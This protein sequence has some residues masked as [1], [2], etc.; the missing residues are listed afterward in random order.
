[1]KA[2]ALTDN[3]NLYAAIDFFQQ[4]KKAEI[5][6]IIGIDAYVA[7]RTRKD[8]ESRIDN[9]RTRLIL[10][11]KDMTGYR[12]LIQLV[13]DAHLEGFYYKPR[14]D[15][16][17]IQ[18]WSDGLVC[19]SPDFNS[20]ISN[21][22]DVGDKERALDLVVF[23]KKTYGEENFFLEISR[24]PEIENH[25]QLEEKIIAFAKESNTQL[26]ASQNVFY[27]KKE[28]REARRT[29]MSVQQ[30]FGNAN[31]YDENEDF[32]FITQKQANE[33]F[34]NLPEALANTQKIADMCNI[35]IPIAVWKFPNYVIDSGL[36]PDE[37]F[38]RIVEEGIEVRKIEKTEEILTRMEYELD[39]IKEKGYSKYFL[40][41][42]DLLRYAR[43]N[44]IL[45]TIRGSVAGSLVTYLAGI[46]NVN[47]I[48]YKLPFE[49]FLNRE[50]PSAPD[51][52]MDYAE[53]RRDE[54]IEYARKKYGSAHVAQIGTFGTMLARGS[55]RDTTRA[56]GYD[57]QI[58][59]E[60][61]K[62]IPMGSQ[63][64]PMTIKRA[65]TEVSELAEKYKKNADFKK[66]IDMAKKIEGCARHIG[67]HAA[68]I[69]ISPDPL[70]VDVPLQFDPK[71][72]DKLITQ[73]NMHSVGE[74]G[75]GLLK[76]DF[77]G[78][79][80]LAILST[81]VKLV[82]KIHNI[83]IDIEAIPMDDKKTFEMLARGETIGVFQ[84]N[85]S[86]M[87]KSLKELKPS[88]IYDINAM[89]ALYRPGPMESIPKYIERKHN[90]DL[91]QY[92]DPRMEEI[93]DRSFG[94]ITYQDDVMMIAIKLA[95]YS[96]LEADKL[97]KAMGKKIPE[98]MQAEK[99]KLF[100]GLVTNGM[101]E[102]K[103]EEL[104]LLIEP[105]AAY[106][107]N[108][109]HAA[110]Y[111]RVAYQTAYM[112]ANYPNIYMAS[113]LTAD[114]GDTEKVAEMV[115]ECKRMHIDVLPPDINESFA[116]FTVVGDAIR[117]GLTTIKNFGEGIANTIIENRKQKGKFTS[118]ADFLERITDRNLNKKSLE[119]LIKT[120]AFDSLGDRSEL[121][122]NLEK[123]LAYNK[124]IAKGDSSQA[125]L[126][127]AEVNHVSLKLEKGEPISTEQRLNWEKELLGLY[128]SGNP[129]EPF[130][131]KMKKNAAE[132]AT[133][134]EKGIEGT[135][136]TVCGIIETVRIIRTKKNDDMAFIKISD[137]TDSVE[138]VLF[139]S[140][141][142]K[143][144]EVI[145]PGV[146]IAI[147]GKVSKR[148]GELS[149]LAEVIKRMKVD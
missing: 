75:V 74:D 64:F 104:W 132:I 84:L 67:V 48:E 8:K 1:M 147:K 50:R 41:V 66:I 130:R 120:G 97:R 4:C 17:T 115:N 3:C 83:D 53:D 125:S 113:V 93:T 10:L 119:S 32:S 142:Q 43:E 136:T 57:Y 13:T 108:K 127:G 26:V 11:A 117:F 62:L 33:Y 103:A 44:G 54:M 101:S 94:V 122:Y 98:V 35:D 79:K 28:D 76:F 42:A 88:T 36:T 52:D 34:K 91:V 92:L 131:E 149:L 65:L 141:M 12:N 69:V 81:A 116:D 106:G 55:I 89:V 73:Y 109:A 60:I 129:L 102:A 80:N 2:L 23:Y 111:G 40:V 58:G 22:L 21:A 70:T 39:V 45:T 47:P 56:L 19:I 72:E 68:G 7:I 78:L 118:I 95:G 145:E 133:V 29:L 37:E 121:F 31:Y 123:L 46:T 143:F 148:N 107:F 112:K 90:P 24:H 134:R 5:K 49:R 86:G 135:T 63:G 128:I 139:P 38:R 51:V 85:G 25:T 15:K 114:Q 9:R 140:M 77:L 144:R 96:W 61:A 59:D 138:V 18:K 27:M 100:K 146:C 126:F 124:E 20:E 137:F 71:N 30:S 105:F 87:T 16:E 82:K 6:P 110:C 14:I 99:A